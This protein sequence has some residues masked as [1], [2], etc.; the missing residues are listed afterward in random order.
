MWVVGFTDVGTEEPPFTN[1]GPSARDSRERTVEIFP[2]SV[3]QGPSV[4]Q[5]SK[6]AHTRATFESKRDG[7][8]VDRS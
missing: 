8:V 1:H 5:T 6:V 3:S 4:F 2:D 7:E